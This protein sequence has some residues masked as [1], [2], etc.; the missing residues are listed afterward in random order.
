MVDKEFGTLAHAVNREE[1]PKRDKIILKSIGVAGD[2]EV[3][4]YHAGKKIK[5]EEDPAVISGAPGKHK[6]RQ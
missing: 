2:E 6:A 5:V 1:D 3:N 4:D